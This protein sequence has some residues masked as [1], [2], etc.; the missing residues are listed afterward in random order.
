MR[1]IA[2]YTEFLMRD[3]PTDFNLTS[4]SRRIL[5]PLLTGMVIVIISEITGQLA[6]QRF[7][8]SHWIV[9]GLRIRSHTSM[10]T[11]ALLERRL[12]RMA[13]A[14]YSMATLKGSFPSR[15]DMAGA[16]D[17]ELPKDVSVFLSESSFAGDSQHLVPEVVVLQHQGRK[18]DPVFLT[19]DGRL[20]RRHD[21]IFGRG[22]KLGA[23][24]SSDDLVF[25]DSA[26]FGD[27]SALQAVDGMYTANYREGM[28][29]SATRGGVAY[30]YAYG[31][32]TVVLT[33]LSHNGVAQSYAA[34]AAV[35]GGVVSVVPY[36]GTE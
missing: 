14:F 7:A 30:T 21:V 11:E 29:V 19:G 36:R 15:Q 33:V 31:E 17:D 8:I 27:W 12:R 4:F 3:Y 10:E 13:I 32:N 18:G 34:L 9:N 5:A 23:L 16:I 25:D 1:A 22:L 6:D 26:A 28:L 35:D 20:I 24:V 2:A